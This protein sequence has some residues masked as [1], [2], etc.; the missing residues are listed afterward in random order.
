MQRRRM[1]RT[2]QKEAFTSS[3]P[4]RGA[5]ERGLLCSAISA[6]LSARLLFCQSAWNRAQII[7]SY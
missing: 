3:Q 4:H 2:G 7:Y 1:G 6:P 5:E